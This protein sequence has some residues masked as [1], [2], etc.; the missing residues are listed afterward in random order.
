MIK[1][2]LSSLLALSIIT[3]SFFEQSW[4]TFWSFLSIPPMNPPGFFD[5]K[6]IIFSLESYKDGFNPYIQNPNNFQEGLFMYPKIWLYMAEYFNLENK[7][8]YYF[9]IFLFLTVYFNI[10]FKITKLIDD[11]FFRYSVIIIFLSTSNFLVIERMNIEIIIFILI[12]FSTSV[13]NNFLQIFL[14]SLAVIGK[15]F[16]IFIIAATLDSIKKFILLTVIS[17]IIIF[18]SYDNIVSFSINFIDWS[19]VFAYGSKTLSRS[20]FNLFNEI[21]YNFTDKEYRLIVY[22]F[23]S[24]SLFLSS[25]F[26]F[27]GYKFTKKSIKNYDFSFN[28][29]D[30]LFMAGSSIYLGTFII[31]SNVDYRLIFFVFLLPYLSSIKDKI[32]KFTFFSL[33]IIS[34]NSFY[35][36]LSDPFSLNYMIN[37]FIIHSIKVILMFMISFEVGSL[38]SKKNLLKIYKF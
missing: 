3:L 33:I 28:L 37:G 5:Y 32:Y 14:F 31:G 21:G 7:N 24:M 38:I 25:A 36:N 27:L 19:T 9:S 4:V 34:A 12:F 26:I 18:F 16:P 20:F 2:L 30:K 29:K 23:V 11:K 10:Y 15:I 35:F 6:A 17:L 8:I 13:K 22:F 1:I